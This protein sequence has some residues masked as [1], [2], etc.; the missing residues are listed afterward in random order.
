MNG[1]VLA[2]TALASALA[3]GALTWPI[4]RLGR[5]QMV[6]EL[7]A[8][9]AA[10]ADERARRIAAEATL[11]QNESASL[12]AT[13]AASWEW[14][15]ASGDV[16]WSPAMYSLFGLDVGGAPPSRARLMAMIHPQDR[17]RA[18]A[19]LTT[20][21]RAEAPPPVEVRALRADGAVRSLRCEC[22]GIGDD[23]GRA[24]RLLITVHDVTDR[25]PLAFGDT[26]PRE[27][28]VALAALIGAAVCLVES[29]AVTAGVT[30]VAAVPPDIGVYAG[31]D[32]ALTEIIVR[33]LGNAVA[34]SQ[35]GGR[36]TLRAVRLL[37][38]VIELEIA[39][40]GAG[41][42]ADEIGERSILGQAKAL[43]E[44]EGGTL[45]V[46][47]LPGAG[48]AVT[49]RLPAMGAAQKVA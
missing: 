48:L 33:L 18:A 4:A 20:L 9:A 22:L 45:H 1:F 12:T 13:P 37:A 15:I 23:A 34:R 30:F 5:R 3:G 26:R 19:W 17:G 39:D 24:R 36:V 49:V 25:A 32:R 35:R 46:T 43:A 21:A 47:S 42:T 27:A 29:E 6:H 10:L 8:S 7:Q 14:D 2:A 41:L 38:G 31:S 11:R 28:Q 40:T 44:G 16:S